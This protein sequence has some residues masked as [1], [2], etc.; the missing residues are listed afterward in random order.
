[1]NFSL[2]NLGRSRYNKLSRAGKPPNLI[3]AGNSAKLNMKDKNM[4]KEKIPNYSAAQVA[5]ITSVAAS[6]GGVLNIDLAK[7]LSANPAMN[8]DEGARPYKSIIAKIAR[9][10]TAG[11][12]VEVDGETVTIT[13]ERKQPTTKTG[14]PVTKKTD[15]VNRIATLAGVNAAKLDGMDNSPKQAL[16]TIVAALESRAS[17]ESVTGTDG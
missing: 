17:N 15:L 3:Q 4:T 11:D 7:S 12:T 5:L 8:N 1:M 6:N 13:Y 10:V 9:M 16:E 2:D 14:K